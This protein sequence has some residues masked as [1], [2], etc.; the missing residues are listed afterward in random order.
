MVRNQDE[1][2]IGNQLQYPLKLGYA[3]TVHKAEGRTIPELIIDCKT[4]WKP[5]QMSLAIGKSVSKTG[6]QVLNYNTYRAHLPHLQLVYDFY[7]SAGMQINYENHRC[8]HQNEIQSAGTVCTH[9]FQFKGPPSVPMQNLHINEESCQYLEPRRF[10]YDM[11]KIIYNQMFKG[12]TQIQRDHNDLINSHRESDRFIEFIQ[13][14]YQ[15]M[16]NLFDT[17]Q[18]PP[19]KSKC[20]W[21]VLCAKIQ[22]HLTSVHHNENCRKA[23]NAQ[24]LLPNIKAV[25]SK[26]YMDILGKFSHDAVTSLTSDISS[27]DTQEY[28]QL[29]LPE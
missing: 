28:N 20:N 11:G 21:C 1:N 2:V 15:Y 17:F 24:E 19:K 4:F 3:T 29:T 5:G 22:D 7:K 8:C 14:A 23:F 12:I 10:P 18:I 27:T 25:C 16:R 26:I 6:L 13:N 9:A